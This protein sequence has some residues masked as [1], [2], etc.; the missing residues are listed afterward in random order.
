VVPPRN[1][2]DTVYAKAALTPQP[3]G[4]ATAGI[5]DAFLAIALRPG[6]E[7]FEYPLA[8]AHELGH[9]LGAHHDRIT[10]P[11]R[12]ESQNPMYD[13]VRGYAN[14]EK[15]FVT[16]MGYPWRLGEDAV[17][18]T[19]Y[20]TADPDILWEG[21]A[22]GIAR[23]FPNAADASDLLRRSVYAVAD[24]RGTRPDDKERYTLSMEVEPELGGT[25]LPDRFGRY[26]AGTIVSITATPRAGYRFMYW[27][28]G[29]QH[30]RD[31]S[32][33]T[34]EI[35]DPT[36]MVAVFDAG[37]ARC[38]VVCKVE[39]PGAATVSL[40]PPGERFV[41]GSVILL[42]INVANRQKYKLIQLLMDGEDLHL[43]QSS[44]IAIIQVEKKHTVLKVICVEK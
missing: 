6:F 36:Q 44:L 40:E 35:Q 21:N 17:V 9:L 10:D 7:G 14:L 38:E 5:K 37:E 8:F 26:V 34:V 30:Y 16:V 22:L 19:A 32:T 12:F 13:H 28:L 3:P 1:E 20:S 24:H 25:A 33:T 39:P 15:R 41:S 27:K 18:V 2:H 23:N 4:P 43:A 11:F 31:L 42:R 29:A